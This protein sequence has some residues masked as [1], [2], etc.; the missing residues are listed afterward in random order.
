MVTARA[1][2]VE[3]YATVYLRNFCANNPAGAPVGSTTR[4]RNGGHFVA[5]TQAQVQLGIDCAVHVQLPITVK[6]GTGTRRR[7]T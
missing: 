1:G 7:S 4:V 6:R 3:P 2:T 5:V